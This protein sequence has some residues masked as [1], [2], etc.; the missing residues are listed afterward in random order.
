[1][2]SP[3]CEGPA[4]SRSPRPVSLPRVLRL[5]ESARVGRSDAASTVPIPG[6]RRRGHVRLRVRW[7]LRGVRTRCSVPR[8]FVP[9]T[10]SDSCTQ[11]QLWPGSRA[12]PCTRSEPH[13]LRGTALLRTCTLI[14]ILTSRSWAPGCECKVSAWRSEGSR[15]L[16]ETR[17]REGRGVGKPRPR[18]LCTWAGGG[19]CRGEEEGPDATFMR[20]WGTG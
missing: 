11:W 12:D 8:L 16:A 10:S 19:G 14:L 20:R 3:V 6:H 13:R 15:V 4:L 1:M 18:P 5:P 9:A 7:E 2:S 17:H